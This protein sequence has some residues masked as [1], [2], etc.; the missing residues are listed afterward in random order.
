MPLRWDNIKILQANDGRQQQHGGGPVQGMNGLH[1]M[2]QG[3]NGLHLMEEVV[4]SQVDAVEPAEC[5]AHQDPV[6]GSAVPVLDQGPGITAGAMVPDRPRIRR[7][8]GD[9]IVENTAPGQDR[10][11]SGADGDRLGRAA[12][13]AATAAAISSGPAGP[14]IRR[15][16][17]HA[18]MLMTLLAAIRRGPQPIRPGGS[19]G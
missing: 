5:R 11:R 8:D 17:R 2:E 7:R 16:A 15:A 4:G 9:D 18:R 13:I 14:R 12:G 10:C 6:P 1:L 3:M 19:I